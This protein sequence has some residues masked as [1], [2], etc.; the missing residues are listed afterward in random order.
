MAPQRASCLIWMSCPVDHMIMVI[1]GPPTQQK[2]EGIAHCCYRQH[3]RNGD[4]V[5][6]HCC[7][8]CSLY[9][10]QHAPNIMAKTQ[11]HKT[12]TA[13]GTRTKTAT[14][15]FT[16]TSDILH[17]LAEAKKTKAVIRPTF[18]A[19]SNTWQTNE[20]RKTVFRQQGKDGNRIIHKF[21]GHNYCNPRPTPRRK[22]VIQSA[23]TA[24]PDTWQPWLQ[25]PQ[26]SQRRTVPW[27]LDHGAM[28]WGADWASRLLPVPAWRHSVRRI[29]NRNR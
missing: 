1:W 28:R 8:D 15:L 22:A 2:R 18:T 5:I 9:F 12:K 27:S 7:M 19:A 13:W 4:G 26:Q 16:N 21:F 24:V 29:W 17:P 14:E 10:K 20:K 11:T 6:L 25:A 3:K 23:F